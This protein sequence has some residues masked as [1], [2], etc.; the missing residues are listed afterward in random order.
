MCCRKHVLG[1]SSE[2]RVSVL[3]VFHDQ[4]L[5]G[6]SVLHPEAIL[7]LEQAAGFVFLAPSVGFP[8]E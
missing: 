2:D 6:H 7:L 5:L 8:S 3:I 4:R 1:W